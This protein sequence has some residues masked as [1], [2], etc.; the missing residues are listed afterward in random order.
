MDARNRAD[1]VGREEFVF[2]QQVAQDAL[3]RS[4]DGMASKR[5]RVPRALPSG[6]SRS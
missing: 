6:N 3:S 1:A 5:R 2:I 4:R